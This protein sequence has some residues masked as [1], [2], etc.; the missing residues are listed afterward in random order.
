[1]FCIANFLAQTS[2]LSE[3]KRYFLFFLFL[4]NQNMLEI[5]FQ[6]LN[7]PPAGSVVHSR[8]SFISL[9]SAVLLTLRFSFPF[10]LV[11]VARLRG[12]VRV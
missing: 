4:R 6:Q 2:S 7:F 12:Q 10:V 3:G 9:L 8:T 1:M 5:S 11:P